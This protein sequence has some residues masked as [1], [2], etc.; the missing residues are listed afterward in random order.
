MDFDD[1]NI[2]IVN[3]DLTPEYYGI[4]SDKPGLHISRGIQY[5]LFARKGRR[6]KFKSRFQNLFGNWI[7]TEYGRNG[8][9]EDLDGNYIIDYT[10]ETFPDTSFLIIEGIFYTLN[11]RYGKYY[12]C[13]R[14][15]D[16]LEHPRK[17]WPRIEKKI[18]FI[19]TITSEEKE[20]TVEELKKLMHFN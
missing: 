19:D 10:K 8:Y 20:V 16:G 2:L 18:Y 4:I 7:E 6:V 3:K 5:P 9:P 15:K 14:A 13:E 17:I 1:W 11:T 12:F